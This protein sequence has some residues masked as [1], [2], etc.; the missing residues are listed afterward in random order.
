MRDHDLTL[1]SRRF[2]DLP[3]LY[4]LLTPN[5][6]ME[7][8]AIQPRAFGSLVT[9]W[10]WL[11]IAFKTV[12]IIEVEEKDRRRII[13]FA[14]LYDMTIGQELW[15]SLAIFDPKDRKRGYGK[16]A[17]RLLLECLQKNGGAKTVFVEILRTN[18]PSLRF[19]KKL[20]FEIYGV[21]DDTFLLAR[22]TRED[23]E[24]SF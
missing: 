7:A 22:Q 6:L 2:T 8:T 9:F 21:Y 15:L 23:P 13:G 18:I 17:M 11:K 24:S 1:R 3:A 4:T 5:I 10:I 12:Y 20:G 14:G 19:F 16:Q